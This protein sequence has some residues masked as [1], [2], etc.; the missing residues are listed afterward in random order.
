MAGPIGTDIRSRQ[1]CGCMFARHAAPPLAPTC[2]GAN[3]NTPGTMFEAIR[4]R[5]GMLLL[6]SQ[7]RP[8]RWVL[9]E[10]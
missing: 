8:R 9:A 10:G 3:F 1:P 2:S 6:G 7:A 4:A 5:F